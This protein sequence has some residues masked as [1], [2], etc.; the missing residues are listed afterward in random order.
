MLTR[1]STL[2]LRTL[3][4][5]PAD[6]EVP[7]HRLLV[8]AGYVRRVAPGIFTWLP[9]GYRVLRNVER[10]VR[11]EMD[12]AGFQELHFP[13]LLPREPYE[14]TDRWTEYGPNLFRLQDRRGSDYLLG[15]TH[16]EMFTLTVKDVCSSYKDLPLSLYQIQTKYRDEAR[17]RAGIL[18]GREFVM[19]DSYSFDT[20]DQGLEVSYARHRDA[21]I[22]TFDRL[23]LDYTIVS[24]MSGAMGGSASEEFLARCP[25]GE[26]TY[27]RCP[28]CDY[29]A[30]VEA[31]AS[32]A[33]EPISVDGLPAAHVEDTPDTPTIETL[34][35]VSNS[36]PELARGDRAWHAG[37]TLKNVVVK[38]LMPDGTSHPLVIG[39]P[40]DREVD[41][42][43]LE[44]VL[45]PGEPVAFEEAD[46]AANPALV[47]GYIGPGALGAESASGIRYL[48]DPRVVTG[49]RWITGADEPGRHVF[50]LVAGRDFTGDGLI[51][52]A[53][54]REGDPC[55]EC[56]AAGRD[57]ALAQARGIEIGHIFQLGRKYAQALDLTVLNENGKQVVVTM[58][59]Y[60]IGV[61]R[62]V[63]AIAEQHHDDRGLVWPREVSPAD[64]HV[65][66]T[67][68]DA[69]VFEAA[70]S[71]SAQLGEAGVRVMLDDRKGVSPGVKFNDSELIGV[72]LI[73]VV[74]KKLAEGAI[75]VKDRASGERSDVPVGQAVPT[76]IERVR[77]LP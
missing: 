34:V 46:F 20:T 77:A 68:K 64:V 6:A 36:R 11:E 51:D 39:L 41:M 40:G 26:D 30:N 13:A 7:S 75:E 66:A 10:I 42:K 35:D 57:G 17:P 2:F 69:A 33:P 43:R 48:V 22:S 53:E 45:M 16:E 19:K 73:V 31:V 72:P 71:I 24:A 1:M 4:E 23:A 49:T 18:R 54:V 70:E 32:V 58:G 8:R 50:D 44:A 15:P 14:R 28:V 12:G 56:A 38:V 65:V 25:V 5:D 67:G 74:G 27:V 60:G 37:D 9:L 3:R 59:S 47:K 76:I 21:Y 29:A 61:S 62:A 52:V 55:P 63:A